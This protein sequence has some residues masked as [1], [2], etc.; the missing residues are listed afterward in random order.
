MMYESSRANPHWPRWEG[1][2]GSEPEVLKN[3]PRLADAFEELIPERTA[4]RDAAKR[5]GE[6]VN[7]GGDQR[8]L[9]RLRW[10]VLADLLMVHLRMLEATACFLKL[11]KLLCF[12][13]S[14]GSSETDSPSS[15]IPSDVF[16]ECMLR[17]A[18][19]SHVL[20]TFASGPV[21]ES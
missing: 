8:Q 15:L 4:D 10:G 18:R 16:M 14:L 13:S 3:I 9:D 19:A 1:G 21:F 6:S 12:P 2:T 5:F 20:H 11:Q 17:L 7:A